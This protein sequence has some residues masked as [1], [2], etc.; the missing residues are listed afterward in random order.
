MLAARNG[1]R[2]GGTPAA[3]CAFSAAFATNLWLAFV[4]GSLSSSRRAVFPC[5]KS[6]HWYPAGTCVCLSS[7]KK[8]KEEL[9][10]ASHKGGRLLVR[11]VYDVDGNIIT[12][13]E[14]GVTALKVEP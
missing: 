12:P 7:N 4:P 8:D 9:L 5:A 13:E 14:T 2:L 3:A 10:E 11:E 1:N 6:L